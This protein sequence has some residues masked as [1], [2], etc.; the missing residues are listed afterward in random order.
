M[1]NCLSPRSS[2]PIGDERHG[3]DLTW[4]MATQAMLLQDR[5][6]VGVG[7]VRQEHAFFRKVGL[8]L[9]VIA[10]AM[11]VALGLVEI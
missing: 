8:V 4:A 6:L 10:G 11:A 2:L 9:L 1:T 5:N 3:R 7:F